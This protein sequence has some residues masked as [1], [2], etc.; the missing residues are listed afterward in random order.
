[1]AYEFDTSGK[2]K[3]LTAAELEAADV[4]SYILVLIQGLLK[5]GR[6]YWAYLAVK[7]SK[8]KE[9]LQA[10]KENKSIRHKDYGKVIKRGFDKNVPLVVQEEMKAKYGFDENYIENLTQKIKSAKTEF[11]K[12]QDDKKISDIVAMLKKRQSS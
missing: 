10:N 7:P 5:S 1:M 12:Q 2:I 9:F 8:Y 3:P 6:P 4:D 11:L